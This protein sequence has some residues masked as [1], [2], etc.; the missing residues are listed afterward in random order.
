MIPDLA[1]L[2]TIINYHFSDRE[3]LRFALTHRSS[4]NDPNVRQSNERLE[5]L[6][7]AVLEL[8]ISNY[9]YDQNPNAPEGYLTA[10]RSMVVRT[11]SLAN[12]AKNLNL[13]AFL[14]MSR[15]EAATGGRDNSSILENAV[16]ALIGALYKDG[17]YSA[18]FEFIKTHIFPSAD[19]IISKGQ[20]KDSKS[21][22]Q[23]LIQKQGYS[24]PTYTVVSEIG[25]DHDKTFVVK[26]FSNS[27]EL[28]KG[29]GKSK[30]EAEQDAAKNALN[31]LLL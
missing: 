21:S 20:L 29:S 2:E 8:V 19:Q 13:G 7:D 10:A 12:I 28:A 22:L 4:L 23:E 17:G 9:L 11:Q 25:P 26:V 16:E 18:A 24:S 31:S 15:G 5:F 27:K 1:K 3:L 14:I 30:Q 6:G